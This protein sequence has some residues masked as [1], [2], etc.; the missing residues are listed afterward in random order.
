MSRI[1]DARKGKTSKPD[2]ANFHGNPARWAKVGRGGLFQIPNAT[3]GRQAGALKWLDRY[4]L[5]GLV[6]RSWWLP[7]RVLPPAKASLGRQPGKPCHR[8]CQGGAAASRHVA[9]GAVACCHRAR[10]ARRPRWRRCEA[11]G[12]F[13][14]SVKNSGCATD[15]VAPR[16][17]PT[18]GFSQTS[19]RC[20][21][22]RS[23]RC[24]RPS[25]ATARGSP[26]TRSPDRDR[27]PP[28][29]APRLR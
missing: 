24:L 21:V 17:D 3:R 4:P 29:G 16:V 18:N 14:P 25:R 10:S 20:F 15:S 8:H 23:L 6:C 12:N 28:P 13:L 11:G 19:K 22:I 26:R 7:G 2:G 27:T 1:L 9:T 5:G